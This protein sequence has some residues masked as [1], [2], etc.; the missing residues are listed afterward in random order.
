VNS[1]EMAIGAKDHAVKLLFARFPEVS[2]VGVT[3]VDDGWG[4]KVNLRRPS[5]KPLPRQ[6]DG[7]PIVSEVVGEVVAS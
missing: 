1:F 2:G 3:R 5:R 4:L 7:V 6:L